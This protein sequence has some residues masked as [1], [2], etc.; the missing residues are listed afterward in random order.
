MI[1]DG[2]TAVT[3]FK[4]QGFTWGGDWDGDKDYQHFECAEKTPEAN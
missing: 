1:V 2:D 3:A 4:E